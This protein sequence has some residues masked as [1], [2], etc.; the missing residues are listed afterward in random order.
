MQKRVYSL[1]KKRAVFEVLGLGVIAAISFA[2]RELIIE[3][4]RAIGSSNLYFVLLS[5]AVFWLS[6]PLTAMSYQQLT[7]NKIPMLTTTLAQLTGSGP[8][9]II[10]GGFGRLGL[11]VIHL[12]KVGI[13]TQVGIVASVMNGVFGFTVNSVLFWL[14]VLRHPDIT[15][16]FSYGT[17]VVTILLVVIPIFVLFGL[18][19]LL[20][21][22]KRG[23]KPMKKLSKEWR[24]QIRLL[25]AE[26]M[27]ITKLIAVALA[28][29]GANVAILMLCARA[30][31]VSLPI[32]EAIIALSIGVFVGGIL[33]TPG[34]LGGVEAGT[35]SALIAFGNDPTVSTSVAL[36]FRMT[37][38]WQ[39]LI[40]GTIA[41]LYLREKKLI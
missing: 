10:P 18:Y 13:S 2:Q 7:K 38:Y 32:N 3:S 36:L 39:P 19:E 28:I 6:L 12:H 1:A 8:G 21:R 22:S 30:S 25:T 16:H 15:S 31:E 26:P 41:Y 29:L 14:L 23:K 9:R 5:V 37:T 24:A 11:I 35:A 4:L 27:R 40:P 17:G 34:G 20:L 33:P